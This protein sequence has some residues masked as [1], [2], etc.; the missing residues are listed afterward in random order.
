M[1]PGGS[2]HGAYQHFL[3]YRLAKGG[4]GCEAAGIDDV[5]LQQHAAAHIDACIAD[6]GSGELEPKRLRSGGKVLW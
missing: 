6:A 3:C 2:G 1:V 4:E 5:R